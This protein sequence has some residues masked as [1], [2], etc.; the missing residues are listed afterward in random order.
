MFDRQIPSTLPA[1]PRVTAR[2]ILAH[3]VDREISAYLERQQSGNALWLDLPRLREAIACGSVRHG[4]RDLPIPSVDASFAR[5]AAAEAIAD[6]IVIMFVDGRR[7]SDLDEALTV[8][9]ESRVR[10]LRIL[11]QRGL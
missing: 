9:T 11:A 5:R 6:G 10:Y 3:D 2:S 4:P 7:V 8:D 1:W